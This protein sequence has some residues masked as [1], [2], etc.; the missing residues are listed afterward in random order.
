[1]RSLSLQLLERMKSIARHVMTLQVGFG[2]QDDEEDLVDQIH[3]GL[4]EVVTEWT[5]GT[6][7]FHH[8][9]F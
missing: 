8:L 4:M 9:F 5:K 6:V 7:S 3:E 1:M 2:S